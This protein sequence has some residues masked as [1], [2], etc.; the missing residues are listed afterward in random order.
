MAAGSER[1]QAVAAFEHRTP[2]AGADAV[3]C[4]C[5]ELQNVEVAGGRQARIAQWVVP[6]GIEPCRYQQRVGRIVFERGDDDGLVGCPICCV[7][8]LRREGDIEG[9][10][11]P[12]AFSHA[13]VCSG[14]WVEWPT[15]RRD[16]QHRRVGEKDCLGTVAVVDVD[17]DDGDASEA[18]VLLGIS[19]S[20]GDVV[21]VAKPHRFDRRGVVPRRTDQGEGAIA[22]THSIDGLTGGARRG[23]RGCCGAWC[24]VGVAG[25]DCSHRVF[26]GVDVGLGVHCAQPHIGSGECGLGV[27]VQRGVGTDRSEDCVDSPSVFGVRWVSVLAV[28][29]TGD[30]NRRHTVLTALRVV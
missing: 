25:D 20:D 4:G 23:T 22:G 1:A 7:A 19:G 5:E 24:D 11:Q 6:V 16:V 13:A 28:L 27:I 3:G 10:T 12:S 9:G 2:A 18:V 26:D 30:E 21:V 17:V 8:T 14:A 29:R 15:V